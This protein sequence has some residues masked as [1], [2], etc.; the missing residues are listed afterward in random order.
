M[1]IKMDNEVRN[2]EE[3]AVS[4]R[5][6]RRLAQ[7]P[8]SKIII[9][10]SLLLMLLPFIATTN[11]F[12]TS[13]FL[14]WKLYRVLEEIVVPY[15]AKI[16]MGIFR[17]LGFSANATDKGFFIGGAFFEIQW[18][19]LGWQSAVLLLA[20]FLSGFQGK[21][22]FASR[23]EVVLIGFLGTYIVNIFRLF[24]V[25]FLAVNLGSGIAI[26]FHDYLALIMVIGWFIGFWWF[27]Y[28][29]VLEEG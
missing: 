12:M 16:M 24:L 13:L 23:M 20:T 3:D 10:A 7:T 21:F 22:K 17:I 18:N 4:S 11:E 15:E 29:Y 2:P 9:F 5:S 25:G 14:K 26:F 8:I 1:I 27:S 6:E 28:S 19:C